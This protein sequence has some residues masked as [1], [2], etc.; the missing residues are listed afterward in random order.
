[1]SEVQELQAANEKMAHL[2]QELIRL[3]TELM[4]EVTSLVKINDLQ[5]KTIA[6]LIDSLGKV[7]DK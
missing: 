7:L 4:N 2:N 6:D 5:R 3:H 1:M